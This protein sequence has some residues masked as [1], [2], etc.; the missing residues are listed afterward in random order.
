MK[1][2]VLMMLYKQLFQF[3]VKIE[4][5][6]GAAVANGSLWIQLG[7]GTNGAGG[8]SGVLS[9]RQQVQ[10]TATVGAITHYWSGDT[11]RFT[12]AAL[13]AAG[14]SSM[15]LGFERTVDAAGV[16]TSEGVLTI[17]RGTSAW[18][19]Q[20]WN[21][22]TGPY[23]ATWE[24]TIGAMGPALAPFGTFGAQIAIYPIFHNKGVFLNPGLNAYVY[25][26]ALVTVGSPITF[27]VYSASHTFM[28]LGVTG[29][30]VSARGGFLAPTLMMRYE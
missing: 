22:V 14:S 5:G 8:L 7:S 28:P 19:Q 30:A 9:T 20:A 29:F 11:N 17:Y 23:T 21:Q 24:T 26:N 6:G 1:Y 2:G 12:V 13:G 25:E 4:Y 10:C 3:F 16:V 15:F 27:T 18:G